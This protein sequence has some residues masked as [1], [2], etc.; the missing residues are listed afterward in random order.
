M[1]S[2]CQL[3]RGTHHSTR[4]VR[5]FGLMI[6]QIDSVWASKWGHAQCCRA[7]FRERVS[8]S[9]AY[10]SSELHLDAYIRSTSED[11]VASNM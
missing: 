7:D 4:E 9:V 3:L 5:C 1:S 6:G 2:Y 10:S 11:N 8:V